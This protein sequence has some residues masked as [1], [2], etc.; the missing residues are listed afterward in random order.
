[1]NKG[2]LMHLLGL[3]SCGLMIIL[4]LINTC[5]FLFNNFKIP[6][7]DII[8]NYSPIL[9][10]FIFL[11]LRHILVTTSKLHNFKLA[12]TL[13]IIF[14]L[15]VLSLL[16]Y[17]RFDG[18]YERMKIIAILWGLLGFILLL[19]NMWF[20]ILVFRIKRNEITGL[21]FLKFY[22]LMAVLTTIIIRMVFS[23]MIIVN[24]ERYPSFSNFI[25][26][27]LLIPYLSLL[28]FLFM[29]YRK[30]KTIEMCPDTND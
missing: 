14:Q 15:L 7:I 3:I 22:A 21:N 5:T 28:V 17:M 13:I 26:I 16:F 11:S 18:N 23:L 24:H 12:I 27:G 19:L 8:N 6:L 30:L 2:K 29:N 20:F 1:M 25:E 10:V 4:F 9:V